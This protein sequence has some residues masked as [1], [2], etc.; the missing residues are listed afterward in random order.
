[1]ILTREIKVKIIESNYQ[2]FEE[3]GYDV[4]IGDEILIPIEFLTPG[5][6]YKITCKCDGNDCDV[7]KDVIFKNYVK[8]NN[9]WGYYYCRRCSEEK[10]KR[11]LNQN[12]G[13]DYPIQNIE[14]YQ[15]MK[16]STI[17]NF[18]ERKKNKNRKGN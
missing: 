13:C 17:N 1:M 16:K 8:Y 18:Y 3:L 7:V 15:K 11:T 6:C 12:W 2:Y 5:S 10:R 4:M 14:I 9:T